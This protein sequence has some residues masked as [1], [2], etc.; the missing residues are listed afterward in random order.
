MAWADYLSTH[1]G[2]NEPKHMW[3]VHVRSTTMH[4]SRSNK[5]DARSA[6][7]TLAPFLLFPRPLSR[8]DTSELASA[9][10][11]RW[12][13]GG[14]A[15]PASMFVG[16]WR[17]PEGERTIVEWVCG[18]ALSRGPHAQ[19]WGCCW[20]AVMRRVPS[21]TLTKVGFGERWAQGESWSHRS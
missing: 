20:W 18:D 14:A 11:G 9:Q 13:A 3:A 2:R 8:L 10:G 5:T 19:P 1:L 15:P 4:A 12:L 21:W 6:P 16:G 17:S 7:R